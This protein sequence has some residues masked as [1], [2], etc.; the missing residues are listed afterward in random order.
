MP[1]N[2]IN[3]HGHVTL[4]QMQEKL[5]L[6]YSV[7]KSP[8][9]GNQHPSN[10]VCAKLGIPLTMVSFTQGEKDKN[11]HPHLRISGGKGEQIADASTW[12]PFASTVCGRRLE[13]YHQ[14]ELKSRFPELK[15]KTDIEIM[16][17]NF[18][19][20][21][22]ALR[23]ATNII[24]RLWYRSV[25]T[26]G[27]V[28]SFKGEAV[29]DW[30][31]ISDQVFRF[32]NDTHGWIIP[33]RAH[34]LF[35]LSL[36]SLESGRDQIYHLSGPQMVGYIGGARKMLSRAYDA[37]RLEVPELPETLTV[38]I[39]PVAQSRFVS[40]L[41]NDTGVKD[42]DDMLGWYEGL[43]KEDRRSVSDLFVELAAVYPEF[44]QPIESAKCMSQY[45]IGSADDLVLSQWMLDTPLFRVKAMHERL[46]KSGN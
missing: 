46:V 43:P 1:L 18:D 32:T 42:I 30:D 27:G 15:I 28:T 6:G 44:I 41:D 11:F 38:Y 34:I 13:G 2:I 29:Q 8:H 16:H 23:V 35:E 45:D 22:S 12:I 4:R 7:M 19:L 26:E 31:Q 14:D 5:A 33:N 10:L 25:N 9:V 21:E 17:E 39:V 36:Q 37:L 20:A 3:D 24:S 40:L